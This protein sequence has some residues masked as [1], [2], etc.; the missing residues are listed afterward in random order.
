MSD[1]AV[2]AKPKRRGRPPKKRHDV[3]DAPATGAETD[4]R[5]L[6]KEPGYEYMWA[7]EEDMPKLFDRGAELCKRDS[8]Q[9]RPFYDTRKDTGES[10]IKF[11]GLSLMK[12]AKDRNE[13]AQAQSLAIAKQRMAALR[14]GA[15]G[16]LG[17]GQFA[18]INENFEDGGYRRQAI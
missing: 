5:V 10:D 6:N 11:K 15:T 3:D 12:I 1:E 16:Q 2:A 9:A 7:S 14:R 18:S 13:R 8:E 4:E 17:N